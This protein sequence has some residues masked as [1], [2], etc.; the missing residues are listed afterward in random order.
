MKRVPRLYPWEVCGN[1]QSKAPH[2]MLIALRIG[3]GP[4][5]GEGGDG[6]G[7]DGEGGNGPLGMVPLVVLQV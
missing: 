7:G 4:G 6:E 3:P 2:V 5:A 1:D